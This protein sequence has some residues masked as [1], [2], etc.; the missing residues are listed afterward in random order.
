MATKYIDAV[1]ISMT[2]LCNLKKFSIKNFYLKLKDEVQKVD[3]TKKIVKR[4]L[5]KETS[6]IGC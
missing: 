3:T 1:G 5:K 4:D 2:E 6:K